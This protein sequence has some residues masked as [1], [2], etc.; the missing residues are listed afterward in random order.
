MTAIPSSEKRGYHHGNLRESLIKAAEMLIAERGP[1]GFSLS[2]AAKM[3]GVSV[4]AP[5]RHFKDRSA[6]LHEMA[7]IGS[8]KLAARLGEAARKD[9]FTGM[10]MAYLA[11]ARE[12]PA[13]YEAMFNSGACTEEPALKV[14]EGAFQ[15]LRNGLAK[16]LGGDDVQARRTAFLVFALSHGIAS[17]T[18][19]GSSLLP[20]DAPPADY[21]LIEGVKAMLCGVIANKTF[22]SPPPPAPPA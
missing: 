7:R 6:L 16:Q 21:Y 9:G 8:E 12:E 18:K 19:P 17:L 20:K 1:A 22:I 3:A 2:D 11:F 15:L 4:A 14:D 10:G 5:Y 13:Y